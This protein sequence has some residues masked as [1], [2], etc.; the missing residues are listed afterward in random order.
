MA[1][2]PSNTK[3]RLLIAAISEG[4]TTEPDCPYCDSPGLEFS[5]TYVP[6]SKYGLFI[7]CPICREWAHTRFLSRPPGFSE[8]HVLEKY[9]LLE[10]RAVNRA[11]NLLGNE[12]SDEG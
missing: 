7:F 11:K 2:N 8:K 10:E 3:V 4:E 12:C 1:S 6:P 5:F 9:Q